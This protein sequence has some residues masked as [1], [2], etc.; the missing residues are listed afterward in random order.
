MLTW[1]FPYTPNTTS[2]GIKRL[3]LTI[4]RCARGWWSKADREVGH[5][6]GLDLY[7]YF[8]YFVVFVFCTR[9]WWS[10]A[11]RQEGD[12]EGLDLCLYLY[13]FVFCSIFILHERLVVKGRETGRTWGGVGKVVQVHHS[14]FSGSSPR[15][16]QGCRAARISWS[17]DEANICTNTAQAFLYS[18]PCDSCDILI[19]SFDTNAVLKS[20]RYLWFVGLEETHGFLNTQGLTRQGCNFV[21]LI[22]ADGC[23]VS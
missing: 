21:R 20:A 22:K 1:R 4:L 17:F 15:C 3:W 8:L 5:E 16:G 9:G 10:K 2:I 14:G 12:E 19:M 13:F 18:L 11:E 23:G 6:E 7:F